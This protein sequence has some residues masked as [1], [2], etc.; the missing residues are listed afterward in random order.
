MLI[1]RLGF[2]ILRGI[3][4]IHDVGFL[5][6]QLL[7]NDRGYHDRDCDDEDHDHYDHNGH[8]DDCGDPLNDYCDDYNN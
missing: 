5:H 8:D 3:E 6:R 2:Q 4:S 7:I 1:F